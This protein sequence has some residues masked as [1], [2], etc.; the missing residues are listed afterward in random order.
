MDAKGE[1]R[2]VLLVIMPRL[3]ARHHFDRARTARPCRHGKFAKSETLVGDADD[4]R[5]AADP[6]DIIVTRLEQVRR[7][8]GGL[9]THFFRC[10]HCR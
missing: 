8:L 6:F 7:Q 2:L 4:P 1:R 3:K 9:L 10:L 5:L